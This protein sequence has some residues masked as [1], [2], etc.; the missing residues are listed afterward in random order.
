MDSRSSVDAVERRRIACPS[1]ES[2]PVSSHLAH[3]LDTVLT[4]LS[5][6]HMGG[7]DVSMD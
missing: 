5:Q 3:R 6:L 1:Q 4:E 2:N 7:N